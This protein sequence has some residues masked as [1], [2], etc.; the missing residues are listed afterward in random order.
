MQEE[1]AIYAEATA[2]LEAWN[3][4]DAKSLT[5]FF[6]EDAVRVG[7]FGD[8]QHGKK[9]I[10]EAYHKLLTQAMSGAQVKQDKGEVRML[11]PEL[12]VRK[13]NIEIIR[14]DGVSMK[15][16][17]VEVYKKVNGRWLI[18]ESHPKLFPPP[19]PAPPASN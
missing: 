13:G 16:Y 2:F 8:I 11:S 4:G 14:P 12:A 15:G 19:P 18:L 5:D 6:T 1:D 9:E 7:A 3:K 17:I 10:G